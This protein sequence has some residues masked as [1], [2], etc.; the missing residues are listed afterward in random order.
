MQ[1]YV[2]VAV[3]VLQSIGSLSNNNDDENDKKPSRFRLAK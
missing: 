2:A 3:A 1:G